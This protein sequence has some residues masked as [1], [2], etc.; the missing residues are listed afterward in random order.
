M[1]D[2]VGDLDKHS[3]TFPS[4]ESGSWELPINGDNGFGGT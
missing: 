3:V 1:R 2:M 4:I